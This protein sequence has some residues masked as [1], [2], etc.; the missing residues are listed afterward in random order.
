M[1]AP[2]AAHARLLCLLLLV[3][4]GCTYWTLFADLTLEAPHPRSCANITALPPPV[5]APAFLGVGVFATRRRYQTALER[6]KA[7]V[8]ARH[9]QLRK[10]AG[11][12]CDLAVASSNWRI[13]VRED[14][15]AAANLVARRFSHFLDCG[16]AGW[17]A[18]C[19]SKDAGHY[20]RHYAA[21]FECKRREPTRCEPLCEHLLERSGKSR[22]SVDTLLS[23]RRAM[24]VRGVLGVLAA[25]GAVGSV[26][27]VRPGSP[28]HSSKGR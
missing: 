2:I 9:Q 22:P 19:A 12:V 4:A 18:D 8:A 7:C 5:P 25:V 28:S 3:S 1:M 23:P 26:G 10:G 21:D 24:I 15:R 17:L 14:A 20:F 27:L 6:L 13:F 16:A 11:P